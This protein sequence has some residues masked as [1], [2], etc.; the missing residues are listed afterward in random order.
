M[1]GEVKTES[2]EMIEGPNGPGGVETVSVSVNGV[3]S[4]IAASTVSVSDM[5]LS[6]T[7]R[8][9]GGITQGEL[10]RQEQKA[11]VVP[12][13]QLRHVADSDGMGEDDEMPHA[14]GPEEIGM[15][16]MGPQN[17]ACG[18]QRKGPGSGMQGIDIEA[19]I[20]R[21]LDSDEQEPTKEDEL[22]K[23]TPSTPKRE[24]D[25]EMGS[26][27]KRAKGEDVEMEIT[28]ADGKTAD[29]PKVG[30]EGE[31]KGPDAIDTTTV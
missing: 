13:V 2:T 22:D 26:E 18:S 3:S 19:A 24:A 5:D 8:E 15:E 17:P 31:T 30:D 10:L 9:Q 28:D 7:L 25:E 11:G 23:T 14:R 16:D 4:A 6:A 29:E 27:E 21:K 12:A 1:E 20:G